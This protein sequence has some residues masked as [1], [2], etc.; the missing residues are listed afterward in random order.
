V[1]SVPPGIPAA[2]ADEPA[3]PPGERLRRRLRRDPVAGRLGLARHGPHD[4]GVFGVDVGDRA[5]P[6]EGGDHLHL[7][8]RPVVGALARRRDPV[9][10]GN[11][12]ALGG[13]ERAVGRAQFV[14][15]QSRS[16]EIA[17]QLG[18]HRGDDREGRGDRRGELEDLAHRGVCRVT[19]HTLPPGGPH[20]GHERAEGLVDPL[21]GRRLLGEARR[22]RPHSL[23]DIADVGI[24]TGPARACAIP[25]RRTPS[26][27][28]HRQIPSRSRRRSKLLAEETSESSTVRA[29]T[30]TL[31]P[32]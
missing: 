14:D 17:G 21:H 22:D 20:A 29:A 12:P 26:L 10:E 1:R 11:D 19:R 8:Q 4:P 15:P 7:R 24:V 18:K 16:G 25:R 31:A 32:R 13:F 30:W 3:R 2:K 6:D 5:E 9:A 23:G 28:R 27:L